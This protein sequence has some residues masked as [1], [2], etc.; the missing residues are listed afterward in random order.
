MK[1]LSEGLEDRYLSQLYSG[2]LASEARHHQSY[3]DLAVAESSDEEVYTRLREL[4]LHEA[5]VLSVPGEAIR[6]HS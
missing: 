5:K 1:L 2:L 6:L 3:L 4:A